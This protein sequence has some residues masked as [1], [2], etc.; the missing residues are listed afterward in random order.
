MRAWWVHGHQVGRQHQWM[1]DAYL[2]EKSKREG[3]FAKRTIQAIFGWAQEGETYHGVAVNL[4]LRAQA[5]EGVH[6]GLARQ[7]IKLEGAQRMSHEDQKK[8]T[9][10]I[11]LGNKRGVS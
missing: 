2:D 7:H 1:T 3:D 10:Q 11:G 9:G 8:K 4:T 5:G 6:N